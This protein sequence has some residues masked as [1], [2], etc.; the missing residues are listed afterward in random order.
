[1][2]TALKSITSFIMIL[3][4]IIGLMNGMVFRVEATKLDSSTGYFNINISGN[5]QTSNIR[6]NVT[7]KYTNTNVAASSPN[8]RPRSGVSIAGASTNNHSFRLSESTVWQEMTTAGGGILGT[9]QNFNVLM[10]PFSFTLPAHH[11]AVWKEP[12][13]RPPATFAANWNFYRT[14]PSS[15]SSDDPARVTTNT[16]NYCTHGTTSRSI[17]MYAG[18]NIHN[19]GLVKA[20]DANGV[21]KLWHVTMYIDLH[22]CFGGLVVNPNGGSW[23]NSTNV[24]YK[25]ATCE[26]NYPL[27]N[28]VRAGFTFV[29]W[30]ETSRGS[31]SSGHL[32][33]NDMGSADNS[34][35]IFC[36]NSVTELPYS[37][38]VPNATQLTNYTTIKANWKYTVKY[39]GN[40]STVG[41]MGDQTFNSTGTDSDGNLAANI[42]SRPGYNFL[43]WSTSPNAAKPMYKD[44]QKVKDLGNITLYA[45]WQKN[46]TSLENA[47]ALKNIEKMMQLN[48][49]KVDENDESHTLNARFNVYEWSQSLNNGFGAYKNA[50]TYT[51][52]SNRVYNIKYTADNLGKFKIKEI[53][54]EDGY[55]NDKYEA[56]INMF[57]DRVSTSPNDKVL[58][59]IDVPFYEN[60]MVDS[61][62][63]VWMSERGYEIG[64]IVRIGKNPATAV[65]YMAQKA[66]KGRY[67]QFSTQHWS[68]LS[69]GSY[70]YYDRL[71]EGAGEWNTTDLYA[72]HVSVVVPN[73]PSRQTG[74]IFS[75]R[76][77]DPSGRILKG[78]EFNTYYADVPNVLCRA[79]GYDSNSYTYRT[80][81]NLNGNI[82]PYEKREIPM[83]DT[84]THA[85]LNPDG[86]K[87]L[88]L[89]VKEDYA[90]DNYE[91]I[92]DFKVTATAEYNKE[93]NS[94]NVT[95]VKATF[96]DGKTQTIQNGGVF[97]APQLYDTPETFNLNIIKKG[98]KNNYEIKDL[99][100]AEY[101][102]F[103][104]EACVMPVK[105]IT[106]ETNGTGM[107]N[108]LPLRDYWVKETKEPDSG[109]YLLS[110]E[111]HKIS[112]ETVQSGSTVSLTFTDSE[113]SGKVIAHKTDESD[114]PIG[115]AGFSLFRCPLDIDNSNVESFNYK[116]G[117][118][119]GK[120]V[121]TDV[122]GN[123]VFSEVPFG[124]YILVETTVPDG[125]AKAA[126]QMVEVTLENGGNSDATA[127]TVSIIEMPE[128]SMIRIY[129]EASSDKKRLEGTTFKVFD[130]TK[131]TYL[132][133]SVID[134]DGKEVL[135]DRLFTTDENG[136]V[137][138]DELSNGV[139]R[140]EEFEAS[141]GYLLDT[142]PK[143]ITI[144]KGNEDGTDKDG[145][146]Y[147]SVTFT[148]DKTEISFEKVDITTK[149]E[150]KGGEYKVEDINGNIMDKWTGDG[151]VHKIYG[152]IAGETYILTE[153][154][155]PEGYTIAAPIEFTVN[156]DGKTVTIGGKTADRIIMEDDYNKLELSK[157]NTSTKKMIPG[158]KLELHAGGKD[159][160]IYDSWISGTTAHRIDRIP[161]GTY[162]LVETQA[163]D[164]YVIAESMTFDVGESNE[165]QEIVMEDD[166]TKTQFIKLAADTGEPLPGCRMQVLD[167]DKKL[168]A[169]AEWVTDGTP[170]EI[171][172]LIAGEVYYLHEV[173][174]PDDYQIAGDVKFIAGQQWNDGNMTTEDDFKLDGTQYID[175]GGN[176][177]NYDDGKVEAETPKDTSEE[178]TDVEETDEYLPD[179]A[180]GEI[181]E[182]EKDELDIPQDSDY[183]D[184]A[185]DMVTVT[186]L[187][188]PKLI[189]II[190]KDNFSNLIDGAEL[191]LMD[192]DG[193]IIHEWVTGAN[194]LSVFKLKNGKYTIHEKYAPIN[195]EL[196]EDIEF[197]VTDQT[198]EVEYV[199][200]DE[201][202]GGSIK[203]EKSDEK[204]KKPLPGIEFTLTGAN[205]FTLKARTDENGKIVFGV[206]KEGLST[207]TPQKYTLAETSSKDGYSLLKDPIEIELP[208]KLTEAEAKVQ[209]ADLSK[210]KWDKENEVYRFFDLTYKV[211]NDA[212]LQLPAT[213]SN[214]ILYAI[215][216]GTVM[217]FL[218][219][220][221]F[222]L[223]QK[224]KK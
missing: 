106:I 2:K 96:S 132:K 3:V 93:E 135:K 83:D 202:I 25:R 14:F 60:T 78:A 151:S 7:P 218:V 81:C 5:G 62:K 197:E 141:P 173:S 149:A 104:D 84:Q 206:N 45:V 139:F 119:V 92:D 66:N 1:M 68:K 224:K 95:T 113:D 11:A 27:E 134:A 76:K 50:P 33:S 64:D 46:K 136:L 154:I 223:K 161:A 182:V 147:Y 148:D 157:V 156:N 191:Q 18:L 21:Q 26:Y 186:M 13:G 97:D 88:K 150:L 22:K 111:V 54:V 205:G 108:N 32:V 193:N 222:G 209:N 86:T 53:E 166:Y 181:S 164:G 201:Y 105:T 155:S 6:V 210:A 87:T 120:E 20:K 117:Q 63:G 123:A 133:Q 122:N 90:P 200:I 127:Q 99:A 159:G 168:V 17:N 216:A 167:K 208:L 125:W 72:K 47:N 15:S 196:A 180:D 36:G 65:Y 190:K 8:N 23:Q 192:A 153:E 189:S 178:E 185:C 39:R 34:K 188:K 48:I 144:Q 41:T 28:P 126:N 42:F 107:I 115:D 9:S 31:K 37:P 152:L 61:D 70:I 10:I 118:I 4:V 145:V 19:V 221:F 35:F 43:G 85:V 101:T 16:L 82:L 110:D 176:V 219:V 100:G 187:D 169:G 51:V 195:Y 94:W 174:A 143:R 129:K 179:G 59:S 80:D 114:N 162:T 204:T 183:D 124:R 103:E 184:S 207:L 211:S 171:D 24:S 30:S 74:L 217:I 102:V 170:H 220:I 215:I 128:K 38:S 77:K 138:V 67:P 89:I 137:I 55:V 44:A 112:A 73:R 203:V 57:E 69:S 98:D 199:M 75:L 131:N 158:A 109:K 160:K 198:T 165:V 214:E 29:G 146:P 116:E 12:T 175:Q 121:K 213:G 79:M 71:V 194:V 212:V 49:I 52:N 56:E 172:Y 91:K 140:V 142:T 58:R 130:E 40:G 163:P 177:V